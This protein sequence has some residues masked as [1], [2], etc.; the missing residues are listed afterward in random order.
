MTKEK[1]KVE[2]EKKSHYTMMIKMQDIKLLM[3][4]KN[5][6]VHDGRKRI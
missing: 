4:K 3:T 5:A 6:K 1:K 2:E